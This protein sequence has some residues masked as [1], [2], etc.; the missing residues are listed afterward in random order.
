MSVSVLC[1][2]AE[3]FADKV[4]ELPNFRGVSLPDIKEK[5]ENLLS[6]IGREGV[7]STYTKHDISHIESML[8]SLDWLIPESTQK[9]FTSVDWLLIVLTVYFHDLGMLV[10]KDEYKQREVNSLYTDFRKWITEDPSGKDYLSRAKELDDE[11][12]EKFFIKNS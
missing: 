8:Y 2:N 5:V 11:E 9:A 6:M 3:K 12:K 10:T 1:T 4:R 7:F